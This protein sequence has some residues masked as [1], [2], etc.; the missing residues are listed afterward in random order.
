MTRPP[1]VRKLLRVHTGL[2]C[3]VASGDLLVQESLSGGRATVVQVRH[4]VNGLDR[5]TEA[6]RLVADGELQRCVDVTLLSV[7]V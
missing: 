6:I 2:K 7:S 5:K 4:V 3:L 1:P